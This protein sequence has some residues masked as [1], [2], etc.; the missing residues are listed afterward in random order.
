MIIANKIDTDI[1]HAK[2]SHHRHIG[3]FQNYLVCDT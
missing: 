2:V 1:P 3:I